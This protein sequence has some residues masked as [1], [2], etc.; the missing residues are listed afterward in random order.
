MKMKKLKQVLSITLASAMLVTSIPMNTFAGE[1]ETE[2]MNEQVS[3]QSAE[4]PESRTGSRAAG[5]GW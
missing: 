1:A 4:Q 2:Q 3:A 5:G